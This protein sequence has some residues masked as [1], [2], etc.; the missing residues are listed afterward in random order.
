MTKRNAESGQLGMQRG[1]IR[2]V[3]AVRTARAE[4]AKTVWSCLGCQVEEFGSLPVDRRELRYFSAA[5]MLAFLLGPS[6]G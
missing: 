1:R 3:L 2:L 4:P 6:G 5:Q